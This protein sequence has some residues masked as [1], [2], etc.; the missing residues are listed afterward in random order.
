[1]TQGVT[2]TNQGPVAQA[3][4]VDPQEILGI[5]AK[6]SRQQGG[7]IAVLEDGGSDHAP[8][9]QEGAVGAVQVDQDPRPVGRADLGVPARGVV[10]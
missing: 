9:V 7:L 10:V 5:L 3:E 6:H 8:A 1:M 2:T 4:E